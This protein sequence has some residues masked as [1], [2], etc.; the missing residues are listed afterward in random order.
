MILTTNGTKCAK[1]DDLPAKFDRLA[2]EVEE[3]INMLTELS[4][5]AEKL[6]SHPPRS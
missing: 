4:S 3:L 5:F 2:K 1:D 6:V